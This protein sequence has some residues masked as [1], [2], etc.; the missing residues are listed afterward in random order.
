MQKATN[1]LP[2]VVPHA[3]QSLYNSPPQPSGLPGMHSSAPSHTPH[4]DEARIRSNIPDSEKQIMVNALAYTTH[5][6]H[7][8]KSR[9]MYTGNRKVKLWAF[10]FNRRHDS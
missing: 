8:P 3:Y 4:V 7:T 2:A 5:L 1:R 6:V 10:A 9:E